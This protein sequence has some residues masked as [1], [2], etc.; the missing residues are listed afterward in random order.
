M[1]FSTLLQILGIDRFFGKKEDN[2]KMI[3][4]R[5][6]SMT[7]DTNRTMTIQELKEEYKDYLIIDPKMGEQADLEKLAN[8]DVEEVIVMPPISGG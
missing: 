4:V 2:I 3:K 7:G 8:L 1:I 6:P 5:F